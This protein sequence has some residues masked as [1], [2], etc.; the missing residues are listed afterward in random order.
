MAHPE[1]P[2]YR[3]GGKDVLA[4]KLKETNYRRETLGVGRRVRSSK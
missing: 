3:E 4:G 1:R 2:R